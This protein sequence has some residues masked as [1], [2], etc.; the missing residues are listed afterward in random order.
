MCKWIVECAA[1]HDSR[2]APPA[3]VLP[4]VLEGVPGVGPAVQPPGDSAHSVSGY[5]ALVQRARFPADLAHDL[6]QDLLAMGA[7]DVCELSPVDWGS[8]AS[9]TQAR[10]LEQRRLL[11]ALSAP[12]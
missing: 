6:L 12:P 5:A 4:L 8:C 7:V 2:P 1:A 9:F 11:N 3:V 10:P